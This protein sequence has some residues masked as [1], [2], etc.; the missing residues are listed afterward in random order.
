MPKLTLCLATKDNP[1]NICGMNDIV[2]RPYISEDFFAC[3]AIFDSNVPTFFAPE[4]RS[5]FCQFLGRTNAKDSFYLVLTRKDSVIACGGLIAE[6]D[7][8]HAS[9][10][11]GMVDRA[12]HGQGVGSR[13]TQARLA[14]AQATPNITELVLATSQH[15]CGFYEGFGFTVSKVTPDGFASGLDRWDMI[16]QLT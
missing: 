15:T 9:L 6:T 7:K 8:R 12:L 3:L 11:W 5:D 14:L 1:G 16:L 4:E 13:L 10:A 2:C